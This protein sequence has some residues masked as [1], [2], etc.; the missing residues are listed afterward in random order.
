MVEKDNVST[1]VEPI[2]NPNEQKSE[3]NPGKMPLEVMVWNE[4]T[5]WLS[6]GPEGQISNDDLLAE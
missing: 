2:V 5:D 3:S 4:A 1:L 6:A